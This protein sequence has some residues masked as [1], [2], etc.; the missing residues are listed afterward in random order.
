MRIPDSILQ[1]V[2]ENDGDTKGGPV[3]SMGVLRLALD[4]KEARADLKEA[5]AE[6][7]ELRISIGIV[8]S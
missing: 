6:I 3:N 2:I 1:E 4:L 8:R 7:S 5:R